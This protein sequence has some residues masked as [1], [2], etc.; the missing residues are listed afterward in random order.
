[1]AEMYPERLPE[2]VSSEAERKLFTE[3]A[4][5]LPDDVA[6]L[7]SVQWLER[8]PGR[9]DLDG[10]ID[11]LIIDRDRGILV[12]EVK[13]GA[14]SRDPSMGGWASVNR[15]G[16]IFRI[17]DP[18]QQAVRSKHTLK[19]L[20]DDSPRTQPFAARYRL[21]HAVAFPDVLAD[22]VHLGLEAHA[23]IVL[24]KAS[25]NDL[26][27]AVVRALGEPPSEYRINK[28][29]FAAL[30][31][32]L[33]PR[34]VLPLPGLQGDLVESQGE[35]VRLT[36]DQHRYLNL[37][38]MQP[39]AKIAGP[40]GSGKT[41][42]AIEKARRLAHQGQRVLFTCFNR[43]LADW[44]REELSRSLGPIEYPPLVHNY[45][46]MAELYCKEADVPLPDP[47]QMTDEEKG[48]YYNELLPESFFAVLAD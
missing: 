42:L 39:R 29:A 25:M 43:A 7:H 16:K 9:Y 10:E 8:T 41:F 23:S 40:A 34:V 45:H 46:D 1:M 14:I 32:L 21:Q 27:G 2:G 48:R 19:R 44:V 20:L 22:G 4:A 3:L 30:K 17:K 26:P 5:Q 28:E 6:V 24:D 13:G 37:L 31:D 33:L 35:Y 47:Q 38:S 18:F 15:H 12:L 36:K 11:F